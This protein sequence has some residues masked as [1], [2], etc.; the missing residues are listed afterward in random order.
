MN[1]DTNVEQFP[2]GEES[3]TESN[4]EGLNEAIMEGAEEI[5]DLKTKRSALTSQINKVKSGLAS[6]G[7]PKAAFNRALADLETS[8]TNDGKEAIKR[9]T[10][11]YRIALAAMGMGDTVDMFEDG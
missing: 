10:E 11:G 2:T 1:D 3:E 7:I 9:Q 6:K 5:I 8:R 4:I